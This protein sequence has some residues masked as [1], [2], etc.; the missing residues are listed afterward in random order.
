MKEIK[1]AG[2]LGCNFNTQLQKHMDN[3]GSKLNAL[4]DAIKLARKDGY[5][6][7]VDISQ[8]EKEEQ[9]NTRGDYMKNLASKNVDLNIKPL[10]VNEAINK[11]AGT[12]TQMKQTLDS[13]EIHE[14]FYSKEFGEEVENAIITVAVIKAFGIGKRSERYLGVVKKVVREL[15]NAPSKG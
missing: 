14:P 2:K 6:L 11:L 8:L 12:F 3:V 10:C 1:M 13:V 4:V 7:I 15:N 9:I 5:N